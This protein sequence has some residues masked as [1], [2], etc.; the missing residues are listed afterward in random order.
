MKVLFALP[1]PPLPA[2]FGGAMRMFHLLK[3]VALHHE[4]TVLGYGNVEDKQNLQKAM[5]LKEVHM[6]PYSWKHKHRRLG[7]LYSC[8]TRHSFFQQSVTNATYGRALN[9]LLSQ[10]NF[11][12]VHTE[13]SHLGPFKLQTKALKVLDAH[14]VEW[15]NFRR[16]YEAS[17]F[18]LKKLHYWAEYKKQHADELKTCRAHDAIVTTSERDLALLAQW[19]PHIRGAVVPNGVD[20]EYFCP[21]RD[22]SPKPF[23]FVF[24]G[25]MAY[26]PNHDGVG[27]FLDCIWPHILQ[28][29]PQARFT[30]VGK[31]PPPFV[32][33]RQSESVRVTGTV[34]DVRPYVEE[35]SVY[36]VPLRMGGGT[37][38]KI[39]EAMAM[40][41]PM[42]TTRIG[43][44]GIALAHEKTALLEDSPEGFANACIRLAEDNT[45]Q[46]RLAEEAFQMASAHFG[47]QAIGKALLENYER[48]LAEQRG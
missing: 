1:F 14:N 44:E 11:D 33:A 34:E 31:N 18:G 15:D 35:A 47:W 17:G 48:W 22:P 2:N 24:T 45:L 29:H 37:R 4:V 7:Q 12:V 39:A 27:W 40:K 8:F 5:P 36:V 3:Q 10:N 13:F 19:L 6:L 32:L 25:M 30:I 43:C 21:S 41:K 26:V 23:H 20:L 28:K 38:L 9:A 16:M 42:V 46:K